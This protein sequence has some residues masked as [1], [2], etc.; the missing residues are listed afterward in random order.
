MA[1]RGQ[2]E[3][4]IRG[5]L[6][7]KDAVLQQAVK[8]AAQNPMD[9]NSAEAKAADAMVQD[10]GVHA[11]EHRATE[12]G[13]NEIIA[14]GNEA[15]DLY[16]ALPDKASFAQPWAECTRRMHEAIDAYHNLPTE[17][18]AESAEKALHLHPSTK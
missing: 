5:L 12:T 3:N 6:H 7:I 9:T 11:T 1:S 15:A 14:L 4:D 16:A 18:D 17:H 13:A 2:S 8:Q 10:A